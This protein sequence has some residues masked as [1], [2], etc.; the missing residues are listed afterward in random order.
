MNS[1]TI[2]KTLC[3]HSSLLQVA[4]YPS[5]GAPDVSSQHCLLFEGVLAQPRGRWQPHLRNS[6]A[7][8]SCHVA[9]LPVRGVVC[10][11]RPAPAPLGGA[12]RAVES[13]HVSRVLRPRLR[14]LGY[15]VTVTGT[16]CWLVMSLLKVPQLPPP[17]SH[18]S[19]LLWEPIA[20]DFWIVEVNWAR[21]CL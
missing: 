21:R 12:A 11:A 10:L 9:G 8:G 13:A 7:M 4:S 2:L 20:R 6:W 17:S 5:P 18:L 14:R 19:A 1:W 3:A 16:A 15:E